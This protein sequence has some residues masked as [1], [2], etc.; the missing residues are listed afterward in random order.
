MGPNVIHFSC[1]L[2]PI[3]KTLFLVV[4]AKGLFNS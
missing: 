4:Y 1:D 3:I 2:T